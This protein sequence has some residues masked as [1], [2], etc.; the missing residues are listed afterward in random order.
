YTLSLSDA[1]PISRWVRYDLAEYAGSRLAGR[2]AALQGN[3][4]SERVARCRMGNRRP[5]LDWAAA[6]LAVRFTRRI[7]S[8]VGL[9]LG[10]LATARQEL[11]YLP[12][13]LFALRLARCHGALF[14]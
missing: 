12:L 10:D 6:V 3:T 11:L 4:A 7:S 14:R 8:D 5:L 9:D 13:H 2:R 1:L